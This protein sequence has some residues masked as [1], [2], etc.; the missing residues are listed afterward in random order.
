MFLKSVLRRK[1]LFLN[2]SYRSHLS[3][4]DRIKTK[5]CK[6][7]DDNIICVCMLGFIRIMYI[8]CVTFYGS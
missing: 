1:K 5:L 6:H 4:S 7:K 3:Y 2:T 8:F